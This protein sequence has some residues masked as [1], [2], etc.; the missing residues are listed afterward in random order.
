[1]DLFGPDGLEKN[2]SPTMSRSPF[3]RRPG[4]KRRNPGQSDDM[5]VRWEYLAK[6]QSTHQNHQSPQ[7]VLMSRLTVV[8]LLHHIRE[9]ISCHKTRLP[10]TDLAQHAFLKRPRVF[11]G[12][13]SF[14]P[15]QWAEPFPRTVLD[16]AISFGNVG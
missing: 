14:H 7:L 9:S 2:P 6:T 16:I 3:T 10:W 4:M 8:A 13:A 12:H 11:L 1:M 5:L 15:C